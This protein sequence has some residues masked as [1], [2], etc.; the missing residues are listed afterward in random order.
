MAYA[1]GQAIRLEVSFTVEGAP[2]DPGAVT[3]RV[4]GP[5]GTE[6]VVDAGAITKDAVG[7]Y[8]YDWTAALSGWHY[9]RFEGTVPVQAVDEGSFEV[10]VSKVLAA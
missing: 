4:R 8:H 7:E 9:Y 10:S 2:A 5:D 6:T 3:L 1:I